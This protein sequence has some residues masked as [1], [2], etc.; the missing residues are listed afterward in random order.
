MTVY[1]LSHV[2]VEGEDQDIKICG[3][4]SSDQEA[5]S[6]IPRLLI[7]PGFKNFQDGFCVSEYEVDKDHWTEGF[8]IDID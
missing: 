7:Q 5:S 8:G 4:Y 1:L 2:R 6:A 3:I